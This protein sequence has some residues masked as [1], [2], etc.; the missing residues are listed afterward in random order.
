ME[1]NPGITDLFFVCPKTY[2]KV[3]GDGLGST[4]MVIPEAT[5]KLI[6]KYFNDDDD[7]DSIMEYNCG[8][9]TDVKGFKTIRR[10]KPAELK[11]TFGLYQF[12]NNNYRK[13]FTGL[14]P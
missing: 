5:L 1:N 6:K 7:I 3:H 8:F 14:H 12:Y 2:F 13:K 4:E 11:M 9:I 10:G